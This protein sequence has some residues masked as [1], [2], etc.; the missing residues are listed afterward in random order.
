MSTHF[1]AYNQHDVGS[2]VEPWPFRNYQLTPPSSQ[3]RY[4]IKR[5][6]CPELVE[7]T[8][9]TSSAQLPLTISNHVGRT[10]VVARQRVDQHSSPLIHH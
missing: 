8:Y 3:R 1:P 2:F 5:S 10:L 4:P 7:G 6:T 9:A